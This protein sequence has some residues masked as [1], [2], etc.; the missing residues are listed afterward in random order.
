MITVGPFVCH[1]QTLL[2]TIPELCGKPIGMKVLTPPGKPEPTW[3][4]QC[5]C[6]W[7]HNELEVEES[8]LMRYLVPDSRQGCDDIVFTC[9]ACHKLA[10]VDHKE[11]AKVVAQ[12]IA[13]VAT[14]PPTT[15]RACHVL[16]AGRAS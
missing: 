11:V 13:R 14:Y 1:P 16:R 7:C 5:R 12:R 10:R 6:N 3:V 15:P 2:L 9:G 8:D 4:R